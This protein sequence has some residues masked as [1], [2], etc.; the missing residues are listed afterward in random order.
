MINPPNNLDINM[1]EDMQANQAM[2]GYVKP[3]TTN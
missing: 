1:R 3:G 2:N